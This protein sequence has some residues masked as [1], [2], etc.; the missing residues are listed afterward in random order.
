MLRHRLGSVAGAAAVVGLAVVGP[1]GCSEPP[2]VEPPDV[3]VSIVWPEEG[4]LVSGEISIAVE[5]EPEAEVLGV[6]FAAVERSVSRRFDT[7]LAAPFES[8]LRTTDLADGPWEIT[9]TA[10]G[11][12]G[13]VA[14]ASVHLVVDNSPP[15]VVVASPLG[16]SVAFLEDGAAPI[17]ARVRDGTDLISVTVSVE[18]AAPAELTPGPDDL[19]SGSIDLAPYADRIGDGLLD[20]PLTFS[21]QDASG[22][23]SSVTATLTAARRLRWT[24]V[25]LHPVAGEAAI[26]PDG[27]TVYVMTEEGTLW[28]LDAATGAERCRAA[29]TGQGFSGPAISPDGT[30]VYV[31]TSAGL[32]AISAAPSCGNLWSVRSGEVAQGRPTV[33]APTGV[34]F[35]TTRE[36]GLHAASPGGSVLWSR[37]VG[38]ARSGPT[39]VPDRRLVVVASEVLSAV[40]LDDSGQPLPDLAWTAETGGELEA[41]AALSGDR[42][43]VG[44]TDFNI[45]AFSAA[46][47]SRIWDAP[48]ATGRQITTVPAVDALGFVLVTSR[49]GSCYRLA[50]DRT[51]AWSFEVESGF[52][53][54]SPAVD[55][56]RG[57]AFFGETGLTGSDGMLHGVLH[58][59][60]LETGEGVWQAPVDGSLSATPALAGD[61][62]VIGASSGLVYAF[63]VDG[64]AAL[65]T[66]R[67]DE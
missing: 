49:D 20:L 23:Y 67:P 16:G 19:Y 56:A 9:A 48:F 45:Y 32:R 39:L 2:V 22:R 31:G 8:V 29:S 61:L 6:E 15:E 60:S 35:F 26:S 30:Q 44:S 41:S 24:A 43:Y 51:L 4:S 11:R 5:T 10:V 27:T 47:G 37:A 65:H 52:D 50:P 7:D 33:H 55:D 46:D 17:A 21:A 64:A 38:L 57:L 63:F 54:S 59:V 3:A 28:A 66:L 53:Y 13:Q 42:L 36:G 14:T 40:E 34:I 25:L 1:S 18:G 58:A 12:S 62:V